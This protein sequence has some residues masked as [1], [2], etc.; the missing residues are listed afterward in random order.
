MIQFSPDLRDPIFLT[1][2]PPG[3]CSGFFDTVF[4]STITSL[5]LRLII[6]QSMLSYGSALAGTNSP[7]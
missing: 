7:A 2:D 3:C 4:V 1:K 5:L 6:R